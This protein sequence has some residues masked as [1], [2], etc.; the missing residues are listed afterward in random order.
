MNFTQNQVL[1]PAS[2]LKMFVFYIYNP[3]L[4]IIFYIIDFRV[5]YTKLLEIS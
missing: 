2:M 1:S 4:N 3:V 5:K